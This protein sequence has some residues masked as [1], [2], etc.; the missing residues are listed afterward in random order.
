MLT[1]YYLAP[2][3]PRIDNNRRRAVCIE[4]SNGHKASRRKHLYGQVRSRVS[5]LE[6]LE[7]TWNSSLKSYPGKRHISDRTLPIYACEQITRLGPYYTM[8][9]QT[10]MD[11]I[12]GLFLL[13]YRSHEWWHHLDEQKAH[14]VKLRQLSS[15]Q[16][17]QR[18]LAM[19]KDR[20]S[21]KSLSLF[22]LS[23][24]H[25]SLSKNKQKNQ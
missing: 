25:L 6:V 11:L 22:A 9:N 23:L 16:P 10:V 14:G 4:G 7:F 21:P 20:R 19:L 24:S 13:K 2:T 1:L 18:S 8:G 15:K 17:N 3:L 5:R 12:L